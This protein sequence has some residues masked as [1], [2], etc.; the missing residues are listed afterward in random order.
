MTTTATDRKIPLRAWRKAAGLLFT[1]VLISALVLIVWCIGHYLM[2]NFPLSPGGLRDYLLSWGDWA[3]AVAI[4]L[5]V[6]YSLAPLPAGVIAVSNGMIFGPVMG[7]AISWIGALIGAS[8]AF[9][10]SRVVGKRGAERFVP[11]RSRATFERWTK[12]IGAGELLVVRLIPVISFTLI[13]YAIGLAG[14]R[15]S[16]FLWTTAVG[17]LPLVTVS[18]LMGHGVLAWSPGASLSLIVGLIAV[19]LFTRRLAA[20]FAQRAP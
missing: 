4:L 19:I 8:V 5:M 1:A 18:V 7:T 15:F 9:G 20:K 14:V 12:H 2:T 11:E 17:I 3:P 10:L 16:V 13:N 6:V